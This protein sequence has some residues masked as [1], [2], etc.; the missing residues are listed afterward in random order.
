[1]QKE[2]VEVLIKQISEKDDAAQS[3][4]SN[5]VLMKIAEKLETKKQEVMSQLGSK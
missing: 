1:M 2:S 4:F 5:I 3:T